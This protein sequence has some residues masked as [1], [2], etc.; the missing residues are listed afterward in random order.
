MCIISVAFTILIVGA[1]P[2]PC[3]YNAMNYIAKVGTSPYYLYTLY[4]SDLYCPVDRPVLVTQLDQLKNTLS[5]FC[6]QLHQESQPLPKD[7]VLS[8][9]PLST[10]H[11]LQQVQLLETENSRL[12]QYVIVSMGETIHCSLVSVV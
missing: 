7:S 3:E 6:G 5:V 12:L 4:C 11:W 2:C 9:P 1:C 10:T 8:Y